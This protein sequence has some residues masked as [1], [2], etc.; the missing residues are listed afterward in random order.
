MKKMATEIQCLS[1]QLNSIHSHTHTHTQ[2]SKPILY[3]LEV[4]HVNNVKKDFSQTNEQWYALG[5]EHIQ[6]TYI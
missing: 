5:M 3:T 2:K 1:I 6:Y 4:G